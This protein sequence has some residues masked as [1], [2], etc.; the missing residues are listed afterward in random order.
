MCPNV[1]LAMSEGRPHFRT[2]HIPSNAPP[3]RPDPRPEEMHLERG[4]QQNAGG[5]ALREKSQRQETVIL[6]E[7]LAVVSLV[8]GGWT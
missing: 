2:R 5:R 3:E 4:M 1:D 8:L 7:M 6:T